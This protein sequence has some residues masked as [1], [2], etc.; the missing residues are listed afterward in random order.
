MAEFN[1]TLLESNIYIKTTFKI[2]FYNKKTI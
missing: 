2:T 1:V